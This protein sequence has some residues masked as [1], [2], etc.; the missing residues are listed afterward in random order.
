MSEDDVIKLEDLNISE[1]DISSDE[2][3]VVQTN[4]GAKDGQIKCPKCG[5]TDISLNPNTGKLRCNFC[6]HEFDPE[7]ITGMETDLHKLDGEVLGAGAQDIIADTDDIL[8]LKCSSCGAEVVIDTNEAT[9][10]RCHWCRNTLSINEQIPNGAIPDIVLPFKLKKEEAK[11][12]IEDFVGSR[13][14][15]AHPKFKKEFTTQNVMGVY[16]PY[17]VVDV[18][19]HS[20]LSGQGETEVRRYTR[21]SGDDKTTYYDADLY[22][23]DREF[24]I[25]IDGLTIESSADK[26]NESSD[27]TNNII[28]SIMPFDTENSAKWN[29]NYLKGY[30]SEKRDTNIEQLKG[31]TDIQI[32]DI[33]RYQ[34]NKTLGRYGRGVK[35]TDEQVDIKG[36]EWIAAYLPVWLYSYQQVKITRNKVLH[37]IAVNAR[38]KELMGSVPI[39]M[40]KLVGVSVIV[41]ILG[42]LLGMFIINPVLD[43]SGF[44]ELVA[45]VGVIPFVYIY[46]DYRNIDAM[47]CHVKEA[48]ATIKN[49]Q[50]SDIYIKMRKRLDDPE[51]YGKNNTEV[52]YDMSDSIIDKRIPP[53][54]LIL[55]GILI[56]FF[57]PYYA[58][59]GGTMAFVGALWGIYLILSYIFEKISS[60]LDKRPDSSFL[61][62][63][64][65][66]YGLS[67]FVI[68]GMFLVGILIM[69][70]NNY[71]VGMVFIYFVAFILIVVL[72]SIIYDKIRG[73]D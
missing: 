23:V 17:M 48:N 5:S 59:A 45:F 4:A 31:I 47:Y 65:P 1:E 16:L 53:L 69:Y 22:D 63:V 29:A 33:A 56:I 27:K 68:I 46:Y 9:Q 8:T 55:S 34:A 30:T 18:N 72:L 43:V 66:K 2:P 37:Y 6:R 25:I 40:P 64:L 71:F 42:F 54:V 38:T 60:Y 24:D 70:F 26:L 20:K 14:F 35:W 13:Q 36:Q 57:I 51:I 10:A 28:N 19:A 62:Y 15:F 11:A 58:L 49:I 52:N 21:G 41:G 12:E 3:T 39:N 44:G 50:K 32:K 7:K 67:F 73:Y 61:Q